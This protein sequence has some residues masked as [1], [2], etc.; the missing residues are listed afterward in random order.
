MTKTTALISGNLKSFVR[1]WK[2]IISLTIIPILLI[3]IVFSS[4]NPK[5]LTK[6]PIGITIAQDLKGIE[7][8][9]LRK[10]VGD[11]FSVTDY[12]HKNSCIADL[13]RYK[14]YLCVEVIQSDITLLNIYFD[15]TREP[16]IWEVIETISRL[17][18]NIEKQK[19]TE[20]AYDFLTRF[21]QTM[22]KVDK[23]SYDLDYINNQLKQSISQN[24]IKIEELNKAKTDLS[25]SI[26]QMETD[27]SDLKES[28]NQLE[29]E[30]DLFYSQASSTL[31][32]AGDNLYTDSL[33]QQLDSYNSKTDAKIQ[34][35]DQKI[36]NY[37]TAII[38]GKQY[39]IKIDE[40]IRQLKVLKQN[41]QDQQ[42]NLESTKKDIKNSQNEF[43]IIQSLDPGTLASPVVIKNTPV[44]TN[45]GSIEKTE[46]LKTELEKTFSRLSIQTSFP[47]V[48]WIIVIFLSMLISTFMTLTRINSPANKRIKLSKWIFLP[49][50]LADYL[51]SMIITFIPLICIIFFANYLYDLP[52]FSNIFMILFILFLVSSIFVLTGIFFSYI[53]KSESLTLLMQPFFLFFAIF[54]SGFL[55]QIERMQIL[56]KIFTSLYPGRLAITAFNKIVFYNQPSYT[57]IGEIALLIIGGINLILITLLIKWI[58][59]V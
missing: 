22:E 40:N 58:R 55:L 30:K 24:Q 10:E 54:F 4:F 26:K 29:N 35:I 9:D 50:F 6:I 8:S 49:E 53:I 7:S 59:K 19:S 27:I 25:N 31:D 51:S 16:V 11:I 52:I 3:L 57:I 12:S 20:I 23:Y 45:Y 32:Y 13:K 56:S 1:N 44:F 36:Q 46:N 28:K 37:Q 48:F 47:I 43:K 42:A 18:Q 14:Q 17:A 15:N 38:Q 33:K 5:G 41:L 39:L 34:E 2:T 21:D